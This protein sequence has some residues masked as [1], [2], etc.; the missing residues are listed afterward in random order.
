MRPLVIIALSLFFL[1]PSASF[2]QDARL[3]QQYYQN[4]EYEKASVMFERLYRSNELQDFYFDRYIECLLSLEQFDEAEKALRKE[5]KK[6]P[7]RLSFYVSL[8]NLYERQLRMDEANAEYERAVKNLPA[9]RGIVV[10]LAQSFVQ[11]AKYDQAIATYEKGAKLLKD[12]GTFA[13]NLG[14]L[15]RRQGN[16]TLMVESYLN[17]MKQNPGRLISLQT[18]FQRYF[19]EADFLELQTQLYTRVQEDQEDITY[20][21]LLAWVFIQRKDYQGA[22]RQM[23]ALDRRLRETGIRVFQF[24][25]T[26]AN[27]KD[28]D[29][30]IEA[31]TYI[32]TEKGPTTP[33]YIESKRQLLRCQREKMVQDFSYT[34]EELLSLEQEY[35]RFLDEFGRTRNTASIMLELS[36]LQAYYL[37]DMDKAILTLQEMVNM[38]GVQQQVQA[39]GKLALADYYLIQGERWEA[40]LLYSQVDKAFEDDILGHEARFRNAKLSYYFGDFEWAQAQFEVLKASTS[41]LIANDAL[42]LSVFIMDNMGLDTTAESLTLFAEADL[43]IFQNRFDEAFQKLDELL[44]RFPSHSLEDDVYYAKAQVHKK[45]REYDL[46]AG[47]LQT[48]VEKHNEEIRADNAMFELAELYEQKL[49]APDK[50]S[51]LYEKLFMD[52]SSSTFAVEARKRYRRLRGD[53]I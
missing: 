5:L 27:D 29:T 41:K 4:G 8:G 39:R 30:A 2:S 1:I 50:A 14:D 35:L 37:N 13:F 12:D 11:L 17:S 6:Y 19:S 18:I 43:L 40:T 26:V 48:I 15:Y 7:D 38:P 49:N 23:K 32:I 10:K 51:E 45:K 25:E 31:Y 53:N 3:A 24:A 9:D 47:L 34:Q 36:E 44:F 42:D 52:Y 33:I 21:E 46:A 16:S 28:Y 20:V 22:L